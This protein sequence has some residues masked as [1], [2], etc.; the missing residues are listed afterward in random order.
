MH[1]IVGT[2]RQGDSGSNLCHHYVKMTERAMILIK[3]LHQSN[4]LS[5]Y[6]CIITFL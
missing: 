4:I 1:P 6:I 5:P 2:P 3:P